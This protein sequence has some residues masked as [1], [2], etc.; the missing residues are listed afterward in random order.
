MV[1]GQ[2]FDSRLETLFEEY[3]AKNPQVFELFKKFSAQVREAGH[4]QFGAK[5]I[6]ERIRSEVARQTS[7]PEGFKVNKLHQ[8]IC[9]AA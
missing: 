8:Q 4:K 9:Q 1:Q 6:M 5:A 7:D 3:H 2:L